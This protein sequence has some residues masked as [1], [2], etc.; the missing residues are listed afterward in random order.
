MKTLKN[1]FRDWNYNEFEDWSF[2]LATI[3]ENSTY[4]LLQ[5]FYW[6]LN[7]S[8]KWRRFKKS[9]DI[10]SSMNQRKKILQ[11]VSRGRYKGEAFSLRIHYRFNREKNFSMFL[12]TTT[13]FPMC[14]TV[15]KH[16]EIKWTIHFEIR[17][18]ERFSIICI[19]Y[20]TISLCKI[21]TVSVFK[22]RCMLAFKVFTIRIGDWSP[23]RRPLA[24]PCKTYD[25]LACS[26]VM[27][28]E[29]SV[30]PSYLQRLFSWRVSVQRRHALTLG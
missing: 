17:S 19:Y 24:R 21:M 13:Y 29:N 8:L 25:C 20:C 4:H 16:P 1:F 30:F 6:I 12:H 22:R 26:C 5:L 14:Y 23:I 15:Q 27:L 2:S 28:T 11:Q 9:P 18:F 10:E 3:P 7:F